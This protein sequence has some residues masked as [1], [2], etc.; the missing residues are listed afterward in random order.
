VQA[1]FAPQNQRKVFDLLQQGATASEI[2]ELVSHKSYDQNTSIRQ[3][4]VVTLR[5]GSVEVV[6]FTGTENNY[7]AGDLQDLTNAVSAQGNTLEN[8][9]V[10][11]DALAAFSSAEIGPVALSDRLM[12]ALEA[13][14]DAGGDRRCNQP[15]FQQTA[16]VAFIA[17]AKA[18]GQPFA[19]SLGK[20]PSQ[21]DPALPWLYI[22]VIETKGGP[23]PLLELRSGY[24]SW[25]IEN[26]PSCS[27]C[28][29]E[30]IPV[31]AGGE[32][33]PL[34]KFIFQAA[35]RIGLVTVLAICCLT[36][37]LLPALVLLRI[38][39]RRRRVKSS[40]SSIE[41]GHAG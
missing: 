21:N 19:A 29:L 41:E 4:G 18:G 33:K 12:R 36:G 16:Q 35:N 28:D 15:G 31:P 14:S 23:N 13:A 3:Y 2:I 24:D 30:P 6:G 40:R 8:E 27:E 7:W 5:D 9:A 38:R 1:A 22:S 25:R 26:L 11:A 37:V 10:V 32:P 20:E 34:I 17:V 39:T